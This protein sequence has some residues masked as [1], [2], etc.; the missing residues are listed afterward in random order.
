VGFYF[1]TISLIERK[2]STSQAQIPKIDCF[3]F[4][5]NAWFDNVAFKEECVS[6]KVAPHLEA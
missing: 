3:N 6:Q 1:D 2:I 4:E 5:F